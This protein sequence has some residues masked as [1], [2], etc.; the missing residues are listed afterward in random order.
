MTETP[1]RPPPPGSLR[2][3]KL[4][5]CLRQGQESARMTVPRNEDSEGPGLGL[6]PGGVGS[7]WHGE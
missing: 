1:A 2:V 4:S 3:L 6:P 7:G 5:Q